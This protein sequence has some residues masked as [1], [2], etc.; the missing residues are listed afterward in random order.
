MAK[1]NVRRT[2]NV[3]QPAHAEEVGNEPAVASSSTRSPWLWGALAALF[4]IAVCVALYGRTLDYPMVFDD[5]MYLRNNPLAGKAESFGYLGHLHE[6]A[7]RPAQLG[8]D[9]DLAT[10]FIMRPVAYATFYL[11]YWFDGFTP[12]WYRALNILLH[13]TNVILIA[14]LT[15]LLL[16]RLNVNRHSRWFISFT[17][18]LLFAVHPLATESVTYIIQ[19][20]ASLS[21]AFYLGCLWMYFAADDATS[22][23]QQVLRRAGATML[24]L[25]GMLTK[26]STITAPVIAVLIDVVLIRTSLGKAMKRALPLL[27]CLPVIPGFMLLVAWAQSPDNFGL[28]AAI[29]LANLKEQ[30]WDH[31][32]YF[33]TQ[34]TVV[35]HYLR[36][37]VWPTGQNIDPEWPLYH[38]VF[39]GPVLRA[40]A[41]FSALLGAAWWIMRRNGRQPQHRV[42]LV[43]LLWFFICLFP[44]SGAVPLPDLVAEHRSYMASIGFFIVVAWAL[45]WVREQFMEHE[46]L[47]HLAPV[48]ASVSILGL[49]LATWN[50]NDV[51]ST[52]LSLWQDTAAKSPG[53]YRVWAN[54]GVAHYERKEHEE[55]LRCTEK[56]VEME[57]LFARGQLNRFALLNALKRHPDAIQ[58]I[59]KTVAAIPQFGHSVDIQ[60]QYAIALI[61]VGR[62]HEGAGWLKRVVTTQPEHLYAHI[63]LGA[64]YQSTNQ[65]TAALECFRKALR[66][67]PQHPKLPSIIQQLEQKDSLAAQ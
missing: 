24:L 13:A 2:S 66:L 23:R 33:I 61:N 20:F 11:N 19:R 53:K 35:L 9:P 5:E 56:A 40:I 12:R 32:H 15:G 3:I 42:P 49:G 30:P 63:A 39:Q 25:L 18:A 51:W 62:E 43:F 57:P 29:H 4:F 67:Q 37:L 41:I 58:A 28:M 10:N 48:A 44:S 36:M 17:A 52:K 14:G 45:N 31:S 8:L 54:L 6:F 1:K 27:L 7:N 21:T 16:R 64:F 34:L 60:Y 22:R 26:E 47:L 55:A 50:R 59:E 46:F 65:P 38:H